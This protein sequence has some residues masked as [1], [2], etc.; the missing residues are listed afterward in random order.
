MGALGD[1]KVIKTATTLEITLSESSYRMAAVFVACSFIISYLTTTDNYYFLIF[2]AVYLIFAYTFI[3]DTYVLFIDKSK[4]EI[5]VTKSKLGRIIYMRVSSCAELINAEVT[6]DTVNKK[7][8]Y[9]LEFEFM[10]EQGYYR[11]PTMARVTADD[12]NKSKLEGLATVI[13]KFMDLNPLPGMLILI[14]EHLKEEAVA[15]AF[16]ANGK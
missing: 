4:N 11:I 6:K 1:A 16:E 7:E 2:L 13:Q 8:C 12:D 15:K 5:R 3:D 9:R 14:V 10:S